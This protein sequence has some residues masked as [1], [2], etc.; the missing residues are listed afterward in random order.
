MTADKWVVTS[1]L[2]PGEKVIME[3]HLKVRPGSP[4]VPE[5]FVAAAEESSN[6]KTQ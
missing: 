5:P 2:E 3:G 4:V 6:A 1:G